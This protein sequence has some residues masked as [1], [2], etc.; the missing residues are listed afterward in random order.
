M[1]FVIHEPAPTQPIRSGQHITYTVRPIFGIP[2]RWVTLITEAEAPF[3]FTDTQESGPYALWRH[4]HT[5]S[6]TA[7]GTLMN[8][9]V[10]YAM[11]LGILG[12]LA[13]RIFV[14]RQLEGIFN[15]REKVLHELFPGKR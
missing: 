14:K 4:T 5:F 6:P 9:H 15:Y 13:H 2:L 7:T 12:E 3:H 1:G 8:D 11:P 10:E